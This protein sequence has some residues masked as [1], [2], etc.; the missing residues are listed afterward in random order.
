MTTHTF[1]THEPVDLYVE[2]GSGSVTV[3]ADE[4]TETT[5]EINGRTPTRPSS[6]RTATRSA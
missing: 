3:Q 1:E 5:V 6:G 4:T 2:N